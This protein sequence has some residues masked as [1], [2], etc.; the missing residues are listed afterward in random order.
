[1]LKHPV[2]PENLRED[3]QLAKKVKYNMPSG[4]FAFLRTLGY[5]WLEPSQHCI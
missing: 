5:N 1:M 3:R 4:K 2:P